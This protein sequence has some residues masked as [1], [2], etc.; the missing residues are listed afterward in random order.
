MLLLLPLAVSAALSVNVPLF[1]N[2]II[3]F[4]VE[5]SALLIVSPVLPYK[6]ISPETVR[7]LLIVTVPPE[8]LDAE[9]LRLPAP[10]Q[11]LKFAVGRTVFIS[12]VKLP[13]PLNRNTSSAST[14]LF[15]L[16]FVPVNVAIVI[17]LPLP[18]AER[19]ALSVAVPLFVNAVISF[20]VDVSALLTVRP[21][22]P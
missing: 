3:S 18:L 6:K 4:A 1:V 8:V 2:A 14:V 13:L 9:Q 11:A 10:T 21:V 15:M 19:A 12:T 20:A 22:L 16:G 5:V 17:L 7:A